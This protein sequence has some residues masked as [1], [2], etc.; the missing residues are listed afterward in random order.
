MFVPHTNQCITESACASKDPTSDVAAVAGADAGVCALPA[1]PGMCRGYF[2]MYW[3]NNATGACERFV[4]GGCGGNDNR[5][6][7]E[8]ECMARCG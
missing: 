7:T 5:F 3:F 2:P 6:D 4:F 8:E 1:V